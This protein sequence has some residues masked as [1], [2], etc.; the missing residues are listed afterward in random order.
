M[1]K[2][3]KDQPPVR[4]VGRPRK[5][6]IAVQPRTVVDFEVKHDATPADIAPQEAQVL[7]SRI[8]AGQS[9]DIPRNERMR[10]VTKA[11]EARGMSME[12]VSL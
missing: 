8:W 12:G 11:L 7:A 1:D 5:T 10:R 6:P 4:R 2:T 3:A 9:P